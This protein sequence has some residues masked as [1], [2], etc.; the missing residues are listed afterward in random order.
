MWKVKQVAKEIY[1]PRIGLTIWWLGH[2]GFVI[3]F[4]NFIIFIDPVA[5]SRM[6]KRYGID[7]ITQ[8]H[9]FPLKAGEMEKADLVLLTHSHNDHSDPWTLKYLEKTKPVFVIPEEITPMLEGLDITEDTRIR[10]L[11]VKDYNTRIKF[12]QA[13]VIPIKA[14]HHTANPCGY[15]IETRSGTIYYPGDTILLEEYLHLKESLRLKSI[16]LLLLPINP[17]NF[18]LPDAAK[19]T[20]ALEPKYVIPM[21]YGMYRWHSWGPSCFDGNPNQLKP[22]ITNSRINITALK[23]GGNL[24]LK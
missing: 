15:L 23:P 6:V 17:T 11:S 9:D 7:R 22:L 3:N 1:R 14:L 18:G 5:S 10:R 21:H 19:L 2:A 12:K 24:E 8:L 13:N 4:N 16:D 20:E